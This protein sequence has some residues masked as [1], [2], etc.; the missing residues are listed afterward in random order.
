MQSKFIAGTLLVFLVT[1]MFSSQSA[2]A[3]V[4]FCFFAPDCDDGNVCTDDICIGS[5]P[6]IIPGLCSN[7]PNLNACNDGNECTSLDICQG[8]NCVGALPNTGNACGDPTSSQC[9]NPDTCLSGVCVDNDENSGVSCEADQDECTGPD[10]C[11]GSGTCEAG[12]PITGT[13]ACF[14]VSQIGGEIISIESSSLILAGAQ[15]FSW[16]IPLVAS[17]IG[18]GLFVVSRKSE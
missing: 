1:S 9:S 10:T 18:I 6:P 2:F 5:S 7:I 17:G 3:G 14:P 15:S 13:P 11:D 12:P 8:G 16:M 4:G